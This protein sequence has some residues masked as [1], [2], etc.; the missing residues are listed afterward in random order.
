MGKG[1]LAKQESTSW[2]VLI[3]FVMTKSDMVIYIYIF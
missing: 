3:K 2:K 1:Y